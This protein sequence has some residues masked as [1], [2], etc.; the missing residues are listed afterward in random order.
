[1]FTLVTILKV[2]KQTLHTYLQPSVLQR[3]ALLSSCSGCERR[4]AGKQSGDVTALLSGCPALTARPEKQSAE[5]RQ[6]K[7]PDVYPGYRG[8]RDRWSLESCLC[9]SSPATKQRRCS[10]PD[11][12]RYRCSVAMCDARQRMFLLKCMSYS[13]RSDH[14]EARGHLSEAFTEDTGVGTSVASSPLPL[15]TGNESLDITLI[16]HLQYC[17]ELIKQIVTSGEALF[18]L[19]DL[20]KKLSRQSQVIKQLSDISKDN[21]GST[22]SV[23]EVISGFHDMPSLLAFWTKCSTPVHMYHISADKIVKQLHVTFSQNTENPGLADTASLEPLLETSMD[24]GKMAALETCTVPHS[25]EI[26]TSLNLLLSENGSDV[27]QALDLLSSAASKSK[28]FRD[29]VT[30]GGL[31]TA[32]QNAVDKPLMAVDAV[33]RGKIR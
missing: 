4:S 26:H 28:E 5:D 7:L 1:M 14:P 18:V 20:K 24:T 27:S 2:K 15:T 13:Y 17:S 23:M 12:C 29:K 16:R 33:Y 32:F 11:R 9:D 31:S 25:P 22:N 3:C 19:R 6:Q 30:S 21:M 10:D 8:P